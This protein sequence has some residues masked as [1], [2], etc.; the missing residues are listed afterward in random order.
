MA[1]FAL[2]LAAL[3]CVLSCLNPVA[4]DKD[5][6]VE[7]TADGRPLINVS[8]KT[9]RGGGGG[10][11]RS[12]TPELAQA[13]P[14]FYE[15]VFV[16]PLDPATYYRTAWHKGQTAK[17]KVPTG[18]Y[19]GVD[20][21]ILLAGRSDGRILL[22]T[23]ELTAANGGGSDTDIQADTTSITFTLTAL[24]CVIDDTAASGFQITTPPNSGGTTKINGRTIPY[25]N[26]PKND[27]T[28]QAKLTVT[29]VP[30]AAGPIYPLKLKGKSILTSVGYATELDRPASVEAPVGTGIPADTGVTLD[31]DSGASLKQD[32][33]LSLKT[34]NTDGWCALAV[35]V[36]LSAYVT[37]NNHD[38][39][40]LRSGINY[41]QLDYG[42][43]SPGGMTLLRVGNPA[44][45]GLVITS[46]PDPST[47]ITRIVG[48]ILT[49]VRLLDYPDWANANATARAEILAGWM[50][51]DYDFGGGLTIA[52]DD[53]REVILGDDLAGLT[54]IP[55]DFL[56]ECSN[57]TS[58][59]LSGLSNV[60][61]IGDNF[62]GGSYDLTSIDLS[63]LSQVTAVG[64][65]FLT[66]CPS[67]TRLDLSVM[68][69]LIPP[70]S[71]GSYAIGGYF[72][73][74][75]TPVEVDMG[76][77]PA[78][79]INPS[80]NFYAYTLQ[81]IWWVDDVNRYRLLFPNINPDR[82][83]HR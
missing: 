45:G 27:A 67:L 70:V 40:H 43:A 74:N 50:S 10:A 65:W 48:G 28:V 54:V 2:P 71:P 83:Q 20:K 77:I 76:L 42:A 15:A 80:G 13:G 46:I 24:E 44:G 59:D 6:P 31:G 34:S 26:V 21:A 73:R 51:P 47:Y 11:A 23:G 79:N 57:L 82:F 72:L 63:P 7:Y 62:L 3:C 33:T 37:T 17:I 68:S 61:T 30:A 55:D 5:E 22:A 18:N 75:T 49:K 1:L 81:T 52:K 8:L 39:W 53:I 35:D 4:V 78:D 36:P 12:L 41:T 14:N 60:T 32:V 38:V 66:S 58:I 29:G 56:E 64:E 25:F 69:G 16:D 19:G 9:T